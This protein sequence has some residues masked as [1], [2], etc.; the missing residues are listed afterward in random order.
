MLT[1]DPSFSSRVFQLWKDFHMSAVSAMLDA[2]IKLIFVRESP[3]GFPSGEEMASAIDPYVREHLLDITGAVKARG[4]RIFLDCDAD[5]MLET[6]YPLKWGFDGIGP[7]LFRDEEDLL[8]ARKSLSQEL[9]LVGSTAFPKRHPVRHDRGPLPDAA[10]F[11]DG[12]LDEP[13]SGD[14]ANSEKDIDLAC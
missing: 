8:L 1:D 2:G 7:M 9:I 11:I 13:S 5:E 12:E 14:F 10:E 4:G 3:R 6:D